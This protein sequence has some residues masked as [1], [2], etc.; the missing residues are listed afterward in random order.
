VTGLAHMCGLTASGE[1]ACWGYG[2]PERDNGTVPDVSQASP[3]EGN[4]VELAAGY[5]HSCALSS[6]G[7]VECWGEFE[8]PAP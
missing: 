3:P 1:V 6:T 8:L 5:W 2:T 7:D 4:F